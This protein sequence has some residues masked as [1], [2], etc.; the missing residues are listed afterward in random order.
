MTYD[1]VTTI[2]LDED[3]Q[4]QLFELEEHYKEYFKLGQPRSSIIRRAIDELHKKI[5]GK[6]QQQPA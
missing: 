6:K 5:I 1:K 4:E 3:T 2:K